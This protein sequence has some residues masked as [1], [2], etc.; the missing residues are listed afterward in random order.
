MG[1]FKLF[2]TTWKLIGDPTQEALIQAFEVALDEYAGDSWSN[3]MVELG[4]YGLS[5]VE[6]MSGAV[7]TDE[8]KVN[9]LLHAAG[10]VRNRRPELGP[11]AIWLATQIC[12][13]DFPHV[14]P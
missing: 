12:E 6:E 5:R 9:R 4:R 7:W 14:H 10:V 2:K 13:T 8:E 3:E 1:L 11:A